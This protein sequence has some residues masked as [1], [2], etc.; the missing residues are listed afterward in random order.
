MFTCYTTHYFLELTFWKKN[1]KYTNNLRLYTFMTRFSINISNPWI[2]NAGLQRKRG[3]AA[4]ASA[5][6]SRSAERARSRRAEER[7]HIAPAAAWCIAGPCGTSSLPWNHGTTPTLFRIP[8][9]RHHTFFCLTITRERDSLLC[10]ISTIKRR[11]IKNIHSFWRICIY[12]YEWGNCEIISVSRRGYAVWFTT[13]GT[14]L[15]DRRMGVIP[16]LGRAATLWLAGDK[17]RSHGTVA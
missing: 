3:V 7:D 15:Q 1:W 8:D 16:H 5:L 11:K 4:A 6:Q 13:C 12:I 2:G 17:C 9:A 14:K 10:A